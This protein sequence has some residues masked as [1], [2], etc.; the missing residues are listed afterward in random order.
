MLVRKSFISPDFE[1]ATHA[2]S[3]YGEDR[4][5]AIARRNTYSFLILFLV[6]EVFWLT[7]NRLILGDDWAFY[8]TSEFS[9]TV[10][11]LF[12]VT[13]LLLS[14]FIVFFSRQVGVI[15]RLKV[16][17][18][19]VKAVYALAIGANIA[20]A[21][22]IED[23]ARYVSGGLTGTAGVTYAFSR[24]LTLAAMILSLKAKYAPGGSVQLPWVAALCATYAA[25]I[26]GLAS[27]LTLAC[28]VLL[29]AGSLTWRNAIAIVLGMISVVGVLLFGFGRKFSEIPV[30]LTPEFFV[31]WT[32]A[33]MSITAEQAF[34]YLSGDSILNRPSAYLDLLVKTYEN[35]LAIVTGNS[36]PMSQ[37]RSVSEAFYYDMYGNY[38]AGSSPGFFLGVIMHG[39]FAIIAIFL[40]A[41]IF[42][43]M[44]YG[45]EKRFSII[46]LFCFAVITD[47]IHANITEY[48]V[49]ISPATVALVLFLAVC[50]MQPVRHRAVSRSTI[51]TTA[52]L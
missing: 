40:S 17:M 3:G 1:P 21:M 16:G 41:F 9:L 25:T 10:F 15:R 11:S 37:P 35:R 39:P 27:A 47:A 13:V 26:D 50:M 44:F 33:R 20:V 36:Y 45:M 52:R 5:K 31:K 48:L 43:Q 46:Q 14:I 18:P 2:D 28:Y 4:L 51:A 23:N 24:S 22:L 34:T 19:V 8:R 49:I 32:L 30:Y 6:L 38:D 29:L 42:M 7:A 12:L